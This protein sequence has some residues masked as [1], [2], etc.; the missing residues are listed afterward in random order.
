MTLSKS[1]FAD[2]RA[3]VIDCNPTSRSILVSQ[4][5]EFGMGA[6]TQC[7]RIQEA[8]RKLEFSSYDVVI[9]EQYFDREATSGQDLL[10]DLR[11]NQMLPFYTVFIMVTAEA[12]YAKVAEAAEAALDAYLLKPHTAERLAERIAQ[13]RHR[14]SALQEIFTAIENSEFE[15][16]ATLCQQ[17][18][19]SRQLYWLYAARIGAELMLRNGQVAKAQKMYEAVVEAKTLP[20]ARLGIARAQLEG[21]QPQRAT[22]T[23]ESLIDAEPGFV[24][25]YDVMG[26][27]QFELGDFAK[28]LDTYRMATAL[29][30]S[31]ITRLL[32]Q[33]MMA[34]YSGERSEG[35]DL[36]E[37]ATRIG[38]ESKLYDPQTL[39]LLAFA[40]LDADDRKGLTRCCD[41]LTRLLVKSPE[42]TRLQRLVDTAQALSLMQQYQT[43]RVLEEVRRMAHSVLDADFDYETA[44][45]LLALMTQMAVRSIHLSEVETTVDKLAMRFTTSRA[46][47]ELLACVVAAQPNF[48]Q[49]IRA[50]HTQVL[51]LTEEA[52]SLSLHGNPR[53]AVEKLMRDGEDTRNAKL[54]ESA[55]LVL[56]RY[57][58][59]I[60]DLAELQDSVNDMRRRYRTGEIH[61]G[62]GEQL[63]NGRT[64]GGISMPG[65]YRAPSKE[66]LL[67]QYENQI[68]AAA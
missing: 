14:K 52:M 65:A 34:Y 48:V 7:S 36:L 32:K 24:D 5:R 49:R 18:F 64:A 10:D 55:S 41:D 31:S 30:P 60:S 63:R 15:T 13:A 38:L 51:K 67:A 44:C 33:G 54:I 19:E 58:D 27:A 1:T 11:R 29:T 20:W 56:T 16:A 66:G 53:A 21:G 42:S 6:V 8:R 68:Q 57:A 35:V 2:A 23:L 28:A 50:A 4:L 46:L 17:R 37:R 59:R 12:T 62:L 25:A 47:T 22:T 40:R 43:A 3:L 61:A 39:V 45:N 26:R 9:C